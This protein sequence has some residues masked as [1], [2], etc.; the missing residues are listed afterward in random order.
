[1][2]QIPAVGDSADDAAIA[3]VYGPSDQ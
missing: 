3:G 1:M 2:I